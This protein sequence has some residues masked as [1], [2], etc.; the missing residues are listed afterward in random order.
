[1]QKPVSGKLSLLS[2]MDA[3]SCCT[4][5][6]QNFSNI[7]FYFLQPYRPAVQIFYLFLSGMIY[8]GRIG[9]FLCLCAFRSH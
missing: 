7:K 9:L 8:Y 4:K 3:V 1:M 6:L 5:H 2:G